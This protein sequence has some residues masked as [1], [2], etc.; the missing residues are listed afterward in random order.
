[1]G[2]NA[3]LIAPLNLGDAAFIAGGSTVSADVPGGAM[4]LGRGV[5][6]NIE[7]WSLRYWRK[8]ATQSEGQLARKLPWLAGW[9]SRQA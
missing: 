7:G 8:L 1:M 9:L 3:T 5:Q 4:A 6:R 2:S